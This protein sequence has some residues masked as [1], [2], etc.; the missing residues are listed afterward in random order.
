MPLPLKLIQLRENMTPAVQQSRL[1]IGMQQSA[2]FRCRGT[3]LAGL[4]NRR[5]NAMQ[6]VGQA[7]TTDLMG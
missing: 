1:S 2:Q 3:P 7:A 6:V 4:T 5:L